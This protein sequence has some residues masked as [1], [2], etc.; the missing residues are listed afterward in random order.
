MKLEHARGLLVEV[1]VDPESPLTNAP[2]FTF[3]M[4]VGKLDRLVPVGYEMMWYGRAPK[5]YEV[6]EDFRFHLV[7]LLVRQTLNPSV[8]FVEDLHH[9]END[10]VVDLGEPFQDLLAVVPGEEEQVPPVRLDDGVI[11]PIFL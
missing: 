2:E 1:Q 4:G 3:Y 7:P 5:D 9:R 10:S 11:F 8:S 6:E